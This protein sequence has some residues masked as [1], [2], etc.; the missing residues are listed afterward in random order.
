M[1]G[2]RESNKNQIGDGN[3]KK[4]SDKQ[5]PQSTLGEGRKRK[6]QTCQASTYTTYYYYYY[7]NKREKG[8]TV[9]KKKGKMTQA[10]K[11]STNE[12]T[13]WLQQ[14]LKGC[15]SANSSERESSQ[16]AL[17]EA[18]SANPALCEWLFWQSTGNCNDLFIIKFDINY[19]I[20]N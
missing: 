13:N 5:M 8:E 7:Y 1:E 11:I 3:G 10:H 14:C 19:E 12:N 18:A 9:R 16:K 15:L 17:R 2:Q 4:I 6:R 20:R